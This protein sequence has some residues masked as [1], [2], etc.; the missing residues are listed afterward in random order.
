MPSSVE[1]L[2]WVDGYGYDAFPALAV[3]EATD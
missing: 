1:R 2:V 3:L